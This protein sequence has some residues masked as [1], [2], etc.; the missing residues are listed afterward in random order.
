MT[1]LDDPKKIEALGDIQG[2]LHYLIGV[3]DC[4]TR[5]HVRRKDRRQAVQDVTLAGDAFTAND[6]I[7]ILKRPLISQLC[8]L[9]ELAILVSREFRHRMEDL[10]Y[11][12]E[13]LGFRKIEESAEEDDP[14]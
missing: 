7:K 2:A 5:K 3:S 8:G 10:G 14:S 4:L 13:D 6:F 11:N 9:H 1:I 12:T